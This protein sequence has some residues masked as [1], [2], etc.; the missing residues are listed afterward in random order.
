MPRANADQG[1]KLIQKTPGRFPKGKRPHTELPRKVSIKQVFERLS[2]FGRGWDKDTGR[3]IMPPDRKLDELFMR[4]GT[5]E[6]IPS[7]FFS[8]EPGFDISIV[9]HSLSSAELRRP[10]TEYS[11]AIYEKMDTT[12]FVL[13]DMERR[14]I[15]RS[16]LFSRYEEP[17][18]R[19]WKGIG[20]AIKAAASFARSREDMI[21]VHDGILRPAVL[22]EE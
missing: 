17:R 18:E 3:L 20:D 10:K 4:D 12:Y 22:E 15:V 14:I 7:L 6:G 11:I 2:A 19:D 16:P 13:V 1:K 9:I 5:E 21:A 8:A